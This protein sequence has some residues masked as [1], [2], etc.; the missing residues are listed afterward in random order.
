M[1][2]ITKTLRENSLINV[3]P[4]SEAIRAIYELEFYLRLCVICAS[5]EGS[6]KTVP[7]TASPESSLIKFALVP[8]SHEPAKIIYCEEL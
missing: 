3:H 8:K 4:S 7:S 6:G 2:P 1:V 5:S